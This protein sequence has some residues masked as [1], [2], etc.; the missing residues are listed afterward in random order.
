MIFLTILKRDG[1]CQEASIVFVEGF[2]FYE[3]CKIF[4]MS[5]P[6][7]SQDSHGP[8]NSDVH[9]IQQSSKMSLAT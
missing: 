5:N 6:E 2:S 3:S 8:V 4:L 1:G 7:S 9:G